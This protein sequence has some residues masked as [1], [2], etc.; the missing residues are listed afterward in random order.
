M[1][2]YHNTVC[3]DET[4]MFPKECRNAVKARKG[5]GDKINCFVALL[6][7]SGRHIGLP[8]HCGWFS[9]LVSYCLAVGAHRRV[10]PSIAFFLFFCLSNSPSFL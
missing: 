9:V 8:L 1:V 2:W 6:V 10:R 5:V 7:Y 3:D 4:F